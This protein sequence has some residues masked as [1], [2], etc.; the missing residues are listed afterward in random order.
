MR[1]AGRSP[2]RVHGMSCAELAEMARRSFEEEAVAEETRASIDYQGRCRGQAEPM[3]LVV[4]VQCMEFFLAAALIEDIGLTVGNV[5][6]SDA[7]DRLTVYDQ[8]PAPYEMV[9]PGSAVDLTVRAPND[10]CPRVIPWDLVMGRR[11][12][13][14]AIPP[15]MPGPVHMVSCIAV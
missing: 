2:E 15:A 1:Q 12:E 8:A 13:S 7:S 14:R 6:P 9:R 5:S 3:V 10:R 4:N 11:S